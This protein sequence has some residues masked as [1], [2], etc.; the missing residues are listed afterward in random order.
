M[1]ALITCS[2]SLFFT[3]NGSGDFLWAECPCKW[4]SLPELSGFLSFGRHDGDNPVN[5]ILV[6]DGPPLPPKRGRRRGPTRDIP[7]QIATRQ[8]KNRFRVFQC[9]VSVISEARLRR[10]GSSGKARRGSIAEP[11]VTEEQRGQWTRADSTLRA[12]LFSAHAASLSRYVS[13]RI[14]SSFDSLPEP[15]IAT[16]ALRRSL[17]QCTSFFAISL[18]CASLI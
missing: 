9:A 6:K 17:I 18:C 14:R 16:A 2:S 4:R 3:L 1:A 12:R 10:R 8:G 7:A 13:Q 11:Y 15:K 5:G